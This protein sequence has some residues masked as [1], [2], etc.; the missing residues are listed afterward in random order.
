MAM[1]N[2]EE[3]NFKLEWEFRLWKAGHI[4]RYQQTGMVHNVI[5]AKWH[6]DST[7]VQ[8]LTWSCQ[9]NSK[10]NHKLLYGRNRSN[11]REK[12]IWMPREF[13]AA[14][15]TRLGVPLLNTNY[16]YPLTYFFTVYQFS[17]NFLLL[18]FSF[19]FPLRGSWTQVC[20][21]A[22]VFS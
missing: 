21:I 4:V 9:T 11:E 19:L 22:S 7:G 15:I 10:F 16:L 8:L 5:T 20:K 13:L 3:L 17:F 1:T 6:T 2:Q 12:D 14:L 18:L